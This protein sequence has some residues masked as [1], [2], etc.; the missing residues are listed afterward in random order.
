[1]SDEIFSGDHSV[2]MWK[3]INTI[4]TVEDAKDALYFVCCR[5]QE[6]ESKIDK[7]RAADEVSVDE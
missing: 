7:I 4:E 6:L 1:M 2:R 3:A 5:I